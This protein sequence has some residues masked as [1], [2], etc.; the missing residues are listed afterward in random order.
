[1]LFV[2]LAFTGAFL[3]GM[4]SLGDPG[5]WPGGKVAQTLAGTGHP[6][7]FITFSSFHAWCAFGVHQKAIHVNRKQKYEFCIVLFRVYEIQY[8]LV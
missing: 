5:G 1:M 2:R 4:L 7:I 8:Q 3:S 6:L